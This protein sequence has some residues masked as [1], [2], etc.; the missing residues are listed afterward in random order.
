M[1][2]PVNN[3]SDIKELEFAIYCTVLNQ[4]EDFSIDDITK[5]YEHL[6]NKETV[7]NIAKQLLKRFMNNG[8]IQE[9][10]DGTYSVLI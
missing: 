8:I 2:R 3:Q 1:V 5:K 7:Y 6:Y 4:I 10:F 9:H